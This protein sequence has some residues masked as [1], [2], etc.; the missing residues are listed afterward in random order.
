MGQLLNVG[1][2]VAVGK[3]PGLVRNLKTNNSQK[4]AKCLISD[5]SHPL[6]SLEDKISN[7]NFLV[8][9]GEQTHIQTDCD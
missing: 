9:P 2:A 4:N 3:L 8:V 1:N 7:L 5:T 6:P